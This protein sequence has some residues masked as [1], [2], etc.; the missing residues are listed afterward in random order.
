MKKVFWILIVVSFVLSLGFSNSEAKTL[1]DIIDS[2]KI[3]IGVKGD[4]PP[5]G[6]INP[7]GEFEGWEIDLC[8]KLAEYLF[9]DPNKV[10]FVAVAGG[11]RIPFIQAGKIDIIWST[12][13]WT[14]KRQKVI[15][16]SIPYFS[17][18]SQLL[19]KKN[20]SIK[21][22]EDLDGKTVI[23]MPGSIP[24]QEL[25][26]IVPGAKQ[27][28]LSKT[29]ESLQALRDGRGVA[30][31]Q[32]DL[33]LAEIARENPDFEIAGRLYAPEWWGVGIRKGEDDIKAFVN[34]AIKQMYET[35]YLKESLIKW[36]QGQSL[37]YITKLV[38]DIYTKGTSAYF[39]K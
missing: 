25:A 4:F 28:K 17:S 16:Y 39:Q 10:E 15:D 1:K 33:F 22:L 13:G 3:V 37:D 5:W 9:G 34:L 8:R 7:Q 36:W 12:L 31:A 24:A 27:L 30:Y 35:G 29:T 2:G 11:S 23:V 38:E 19:V 21:E 18:G 20:S 32:A 26:K 6:V 14:E